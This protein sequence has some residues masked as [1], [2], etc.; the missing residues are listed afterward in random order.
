M[1]VK[2]AK[3]PEKCHFSSGLE[4]T[5]GSEIGPAAGLAGLKSLYLDTFWYV[6]FMMGLV[7]R[8]RENECDFVD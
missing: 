6:G 4:C 8:D 1:E 2:K 7:C 5:E 3:L